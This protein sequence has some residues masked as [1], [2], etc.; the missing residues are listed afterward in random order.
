MLKKNYTKEEILE[1]LIESVMS[2]NPSLFKQCLWSESLEINAVN[3]MMYYWYYKGM[4]NCTKSSSMGELYLK[5]EKYNSNK[6][7][8]YY[9]FY[10][11]YH[12]YTRLTVEVIDKGDKVQVD[13][14][15]F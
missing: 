1:I 10:D 12:T 8:Q 14:M 9:N 11:N 15:P 5:I 6:E 2:F 3:K 7:A 13:V 4:V